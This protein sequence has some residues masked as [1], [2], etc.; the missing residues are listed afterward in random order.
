M[1]HNLARLAMKTKREDEVGNGS[2]PP[3]TAVR[4]AGE[5]RP[6]PPG[7][8]RPLPPPSTIPNPHP[9]PLPTPVH[10]FYNINFVQMQFLCVQVSFLRPV[11]HMDTL[12][13]MSAT[14]HIVTLRSWPPDASHPPPREMARDVTQSVCT[15]S[16][17]VGALQTLQGMSPMYAR[18]LWG[19]RGRGGAGRGFKEH[20]WTLQL[21][22]LG[23]GLG[24]KG[25]KAT[26]T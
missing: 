10:D 6:L 26:C 2:E 12:A 17:R 18:S 7:P 3:A 21:T 15:R 19:G 20:S 22:A 16:L 11:L 8:R 1:T 9:T 14:F 5:A 23:S 13:W 24:A 25:S 4:K